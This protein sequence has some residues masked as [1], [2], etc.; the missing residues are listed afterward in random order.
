M[1]PGFSEPVFPLGEIDTI[2]FLHDLRIQGNLLS[3]LLKDLKYVYL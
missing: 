3:L 1:R 2:F